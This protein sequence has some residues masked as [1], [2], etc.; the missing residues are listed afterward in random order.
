M[1]VLPP[2]CSLRGMLYPAQGGPVR[3]GRT[4]LRFGGGGLARWQ[5]L[6]M[7]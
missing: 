5:G 1:M 3:E 4:F 2:E 6:V 7:W